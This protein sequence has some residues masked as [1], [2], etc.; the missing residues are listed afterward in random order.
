MYLLNNPVSS[1]LWPDAPKTKSPRCV[2]TESE[3]K[4][5][6]PILKTKTQRDISSI[7]TFVSGS[8]KESRYLPMSYVNDVDPATQ[9]P[10]D[11]MLTPYVDDANLCPV[12]MCWLKEAALRKKRTTNLDEKSSHFSKINQIMLL[13]GEN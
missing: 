9:C 10:V 6:G 11:Q 12:V 1:S 8:V 4:L 13:Q 5:C 3:T 2:W 7:T